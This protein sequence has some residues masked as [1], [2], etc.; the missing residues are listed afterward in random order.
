MRVLKVSK[1]NLNEAAKA[2][3]NG[4][5]L[6]CPTDTVYGLLC[7]AA[8]KKAVG[9]LFKLKKR[10]SK[11][12]IPMFVKDISMAKRIARINKKEEDFLRK[13]WPGKVTAVLISKKGK[14]T[15]GIRIP[16]YKFVLNLLKKVNCPLTGTSAN[17]SGKPSSTKIKEVLK[18]FENQ[19]YQPDLVLDADNLKSSRPSMVIDLTQ[20]YKILRK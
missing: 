12:P 6:V 19:K 11:K 16:K 3:K 14:G 5:V 15:I 1:Q 20:D 7:D 2:I 18:Q 9:N 4:K 17:I 10:S 8:N 13:V